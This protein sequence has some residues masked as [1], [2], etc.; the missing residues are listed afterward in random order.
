MRPT[1]GNRQG[2]S[3]TNMRN[4]TDH[5]ESRNAADTDRVL[6]TL[7][8]KDGAEEL[9]I[10]VRSYQG[11]RYADAR[12]YYCAEDGEFRPTS[13]GITIRKHELPAV[14]S[15]LESALTDLDGRKVSEP[16]PTEGWK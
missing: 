2:A 3:S 12:L 7:P 11:R 16:D 6:A 9:R 4:V 1:D 8:R 13:K 5:N 10:A 14:L 15:A